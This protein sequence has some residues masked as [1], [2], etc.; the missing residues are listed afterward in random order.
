MHLFKS[1]FVYN[2]GEQCDT[3]F[4]REEFQN[5]AVIIDAMAVIQALKGKWKTFGELCDA[6]LYSILKLAR[7]WKATRIDFVADR[8]PAISIKNP[9][10]ARRAGNAG[11]QKVHVFSKDQN[12]PKQWK[13]FLSLG[14]NKE[15]LISFLCEHWR[16]YT[17]SRLGNLA[18]LYATS[19]E[20][21]YSF[22]RGIADECLV[23]CNEVLE[24]ESN[25]EEADTRLLL[26]AAVA[27][28]RVI[29]K[30]PDTDVFLLCILM[31]RAIGK[32]VYF[33]TGTGNR[34]RLIDIQAVVETMDEK[35]CQCLPGFHAF[36][37]ILVFNLSL[38]RL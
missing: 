16:S 33:M 26:H 8:Y 4:N 35:V 36:S 17:S 3:E 2:Q 22:S 9:E 1:S 37:G 27:N 15:S 21:C 31:Q 12:V 6:I 11:V 38:A 14:E 7:E 24:L 19:K 20:K 29:I 18:V 13:K 25:H 5:N 34:F 30:S 10:R 32:D 28:D 23:V